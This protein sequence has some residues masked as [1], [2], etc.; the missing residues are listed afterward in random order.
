MVRFK[1][2]RIIEEV[3]NNQAKCKEYRQ[4][5]L[6]HRHLWAKDIQASLEKFLEEGGNETMTATAGEDASSGEQITYTL[7]SL[8]VFQD[9]INELKAEETDIKDITSTTLG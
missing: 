4:P 7:P 9:R 2:H 5:F 6:K 3:E 8:S 1:V